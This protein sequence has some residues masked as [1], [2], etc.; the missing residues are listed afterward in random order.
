MSL[1]YAVVRTVQGWS[2]NEDGRSVERCG[3]QAEAVEVAQLL[4]VGAK[5]A[6][7]QAKLMV[8]G[9]SGELE[10]WDVDRAL[11]IMDAVLARRSLTGVSI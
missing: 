5:S 1:T 6:G 11:T 2:V 7:R 3:A 4:A 10:S 8:E 9:V